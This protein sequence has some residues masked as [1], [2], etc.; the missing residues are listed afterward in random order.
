LSSLT[1]VCKNKNCAVKV[2]EQKF[3]KKASASDGLASV[4][5]ACKALKDKAYRESN[6]AKIAE[7][8]S[9]YRLANSEAVASTNKAYYA[10]NKER[11]ATVA[12]KYRDTNKEEL[13]RKKAAWYKTPDGIACS[14]RAKQKRRVLKMST[15][16][17]SMTK[18]SL[19]ELLMVQN[20]SCFYCGKQFGAV[21]T[22]DVHLDHYY[23]LSKGG[24]HSIGNVVWA[25]QKCNTS[26]KDTV[27]EEPLTFKVTAPHTKGLSNEYR[28]S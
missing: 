15:S 13:K 6:K 7:G 20:N 1:K 14:R 27:L 22:S 3:H 25:C 21:M 24:L 4:C 28:N 11:I 16:D 9:A 12:K 19:D 23:P 18:D 17:N 5:K 10:S 26:K 8:K 2:C